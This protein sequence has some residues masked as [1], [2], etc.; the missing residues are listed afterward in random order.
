M[1]IAGCFVEV[2]GE[3]DGDGVTGDAGDEKDAEE[4]CVRGKMGR[5]VS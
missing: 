5:K 2:K 3:L 1:R 4:L